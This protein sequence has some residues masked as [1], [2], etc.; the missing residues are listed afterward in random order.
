MLGKP[1]NPHFWFEIALVTF[2]SPLEDPGPR[3]LDRLLGPEGMVEV[4]LVWLCLALNIGWR[5]VLHTEKTPIFSDASSRKLPEPNFRQFSSDL[6][7]FMFYTAN[8]DQWQIEASRELFRRG[9]RFLISRKIWLG[10]LN[11]AQTFRTQVMVTNAFF[12]FLLFLAKS[13]NYEGCNENFL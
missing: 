2:R 4:L 6:L 8:L 11:V 3:L 9:W 1:L 7:F 5:D 12:L 10:C 13:A